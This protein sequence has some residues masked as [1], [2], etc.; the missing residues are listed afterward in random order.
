VSLGTAARLFRLTKLPLLLLMAA[1][2]ALNFV[3]ILAAGAAVVFR[4]VA[5]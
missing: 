1:G 2:F 5:G 3:V 4:L